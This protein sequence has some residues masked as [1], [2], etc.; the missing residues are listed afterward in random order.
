[1]ERLVEAG[2]R[3]KSLAGHEYDEDG[4]E[5]KTIR[6]GEFDEFCA[7]LKAVEESQ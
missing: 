6:K 3:I 2:K 5:Y 4:A 7:V 1:V